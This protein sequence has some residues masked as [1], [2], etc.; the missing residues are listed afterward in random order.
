MTIVSISLYRPFRPFRGVADR[1]VPIFET[2]A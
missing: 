1:G 2:A